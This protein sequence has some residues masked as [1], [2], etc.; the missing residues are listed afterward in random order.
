MKAKLHMRARLGQLLIAHVF[1]DK[2][3]SG[4]QRVRLL[5]AVRE[6]EEKVAE[7]YGDLAETPLILACATQ[8][9]SRR[10]GSGTAL[11]FPC[12]T[13]PHS[14]PSIARGRH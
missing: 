7:F 8:V 1:I 6:G 3:M 12:R 9:C 14:Q 13:S 10:I 2:A 4:R 5:N 11:S